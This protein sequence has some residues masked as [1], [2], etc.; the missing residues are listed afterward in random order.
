MNEGSLDE[1]ILSLWSNRNLSYEKRR[2]LM[3]LH[4]TE[5]PSQF[6]V[7]HVLIQQVEELEK[8]AKQRKLVNYKRAMRR[9]KLK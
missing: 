3:L 1:R 4:H 9:K 6:Q 7:E 5:H 2:A 8:R